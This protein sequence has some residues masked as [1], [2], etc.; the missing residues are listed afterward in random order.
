MRMQSLEQKNHK[1][2]IV[3]RVLN[4]PEEYKTRLESLINYL[5]NKREIL[6]ILSLESSGLIEEIQ[7]SERYESR[8]RVLPLTGENREHARRILLRYFNNVFRDVLKEE[9]SHGLEDEARDRV[10]GFFAEIM[11]KEDK[12]VEIFNPFVLELYNKYEKRFGEGGVSTVYGVVD[13]PTFMG[14]MLARFVLEGKAE[15][16]GIDFTDKNFPLKEEVAKEYFGKLW[17]QKMLF[18]DLLQAVRW[19]NKISYSIIENFVDKTFKKTE[20]RAI[21]VKAFVEM[22]KNRGFELGELSQEMQKKANNFIERIRCERFKGEIENAEIMRGIEGFS[23]NM[24]RPKE[25]E[26]VS[27]E[28]TTTPKKKIS[29]KAMMV[30][31]EIKKRKLTSIEA[32][33]LGRIMLKV[34][35]SA[36]KDYAYNAGLIPQGIVKKIIDHVEKAGIKVTFQ[37]SL[38]KKEKEYI[39]RMAKRRSKIERRE[40]KKWLMENGRVLEGYITKPLDEAMQIIEHNGRKIKGKKKG[41]AEVSASN[42]E[43]KKH[44]TDDKRM[45]VKEKAEPFS[46]S[47]RY[48]FVQ[49]V[50]AIKSKG[51]DEISLPELFK[52][53]EELG[54]RRTVNAHYSVKVFSGTVIKKV[55]RFL[56]SRRIIVTHAHAL[57][58]EEK[59]DI[60]EFAKTICKEEGGKKTVQFRKIYSRVVEGGRFAVGYLRSAIKEACT[61]LYVEGY[62]IKDV[63]AVLLGSIVAN[64]NEQ[65]KKTQIPKDEQKKLLEIFIDFYYRDG[66]RKIETKEKFGILREKT[67][68]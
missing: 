49:L 50:N 20:K 36:R 3:E 5:N 25:A 33:Y 26:S 39:L 57:T 12:A 45:H 7:K 35:Y 18:L 58:P 63:P 6:T 42:P 52:L 10:A 51:K 37:Q 53:M 8:Y 56:D 32:A 34:G 40:V 16:R 21:I 30:L 27:S 44:R 31:D 9:K 2:R 15:K 1:N 13:K 55:M 68:K 47:T 66:M 38:S 54:Y 43:P 28:K 19:D 22:A 29:E 64:L 61:V 60:K 59:E 65:L 62:M 11:L 17:K 4:D 48:H 23:W 46:A 41:M 24:W 14:E 67:K